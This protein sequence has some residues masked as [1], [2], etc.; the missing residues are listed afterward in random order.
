MVTSPEAA[1]TKPEPQR[2]RQSSVG[3]KAITRDRRPSGSSTFRGRSDSL[4]SAKPIQPSS[5]RLGSV[6][7]VHGT[8][9][10]APTLAGEALGLGKDLEGGHDM[11]AHLHGSLSEQIELTRK[12]KRRLARCF[13]VFRLPPTASDTNLSECP[14]TRNGALSGPKRAK[15]DEKPLHS[16]QKGLGKRPTSIHAP[17]SASS[18]SFPSSP[19]A[20][21]RTTSLPG[22]SSKPLIRTSSLTP[23]SPSKRLPS[24]LAS[25]RSS[26]FTSISPR[27]SFLRSQ[28]TSNPSRFPTPIYSPTEKGTESSDTATLPLPRPAVTSPIVPFFI[29]PIHSASIFPRFSDLDPRS[30][31]AQWLTYTDLASTVVEIQVW[32]ETP[33][34][35]D[36]KDT[37]SRKWKLLEG[38]GGIVQ[39]DRLA[40]KTGQG[41]P[42]S[43][44]L[45]F[46]FDPKGVYCVTPSE[47]S[48]ETVSAL[49]E[50]QKLKDSRIK[51]GVGVGSLHQ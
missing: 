15:S 12:E 2:P 44:E 47:S 38:V 31:F 22:P 5:P 46:S 11:S 49:A 7:R 4:V 30:D 9:H 35:C 21:T 1:S 24:P 19:R 16:N 39:L 8:R 6:P 14:S 42:N 23:H 29:S 3:P 13:V 18:K 37:E 40:R 34:I 10:R 33:D 50:N 20:V 32:V 41:S 27:N 36:G 17:S 28:S 51:K 45:T 25:P 43:L 26:E 48:Q